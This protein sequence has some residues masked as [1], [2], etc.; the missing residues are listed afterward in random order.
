[1]AAYEITYKLRREVNELPKAEAEA[2]EPKK[3]RVSATSATLAL[4][5]VANDLKNDN[6]V[7]GKGEV[8][9]LEARVVG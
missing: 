6:V 4:S 2:L 9:F 8:I 7:S 5:Q 1:M 3:V